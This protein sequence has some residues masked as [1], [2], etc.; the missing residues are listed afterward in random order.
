MEQAEASGFAIQV[1]Q[2]PREQFMLQLESAGTD[3]DWSAFFRTKVASRR[4]DGSGE[5]SPPD[6]PPAAEL[7][8]PGY[9]LWLDEPD[10]WEKLPRRFRVSG[11][12]FRR[13]H[14]TD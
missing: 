8:H 13:D 3:G 4:R 7:P 1:D 11:W 14:Q 9:Y 6:S 10:D 12:C 2:A 5:C